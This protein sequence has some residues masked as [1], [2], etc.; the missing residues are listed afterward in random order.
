MEIIDLG[1]YTLKEEYLD[2][3][4][5]KDYPSNKVHG[6]R[7]F[8]IC[9]KDNKE[10]N[11]YWAIPISS[12]IEKYKVIFEKYPNAGEIIHLFG[13]KDSAILTQNI[14][15]VHKNLVKKEFT[16]NGIHFKILK[17]EFKKDILKKA[18][19]MKALILNGKMHNTN[20]IKKLYEK[21]IEYDKEQRLLESKSE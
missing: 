18:R 10:K 20:K 21:M 9:F 2:E 15:P 17:K 11:I 16:V 6:E 3:Y 8:F 4:Y 1:L 5:L 14:V 12:Q 13:K 19:Y 7:P